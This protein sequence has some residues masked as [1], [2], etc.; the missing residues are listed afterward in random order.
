MNI[1]RGTNFGAVPPSP[2][3]AFITV[4][5]F[6]LFCG[7]MILPAQGNSK[8]APGPLG[9]WKDR[10]LERYVLISKD[11]AGNLEGTYYV[12]A[13]P[14][15]MDFD[16]ISYE[17][18]NLRFG[19]KGNFTF[20][21][22]VTKDGMSIDGQIRLV[23]QKTSGPMILTRDTEAEKIQEDLL[24]PKYTGYTYTPPQETGDGWTCSTMEAEGLKP[25]KI[26]SLIRETREGKYK[27][28]HSILVVKNGKLVLEEYFSGRM[29]RGYPARF[30]RDRKH[31][32]CSITK[33]VT[34]A[35]IGIAIRQNKIKSMHEKISTYFP[36]FRETLRVEGKNQL[37]LEHLMTMTAGFEWDE[38]TYAYVDPRN[39][40]IAAVR[41]GNI[42]K[43]LFER[44]LRANPGE[45]FTYNSALTITQGEILKRAT[46]L[47][48]DRYAEEHLF[49]PLGISDY[50]WNKSAGQVVQTGG[51]LLLRPRDLAKFGQLYLNR[52]KWNGARILSEEWINASTWRHSGIRGVNYAYNWDL[53]QFNLDQLAVEAYYHSG[54]GGQYLFVI[55]RFDMVVVFTSG[56]YD[57]P[58]SSQPEDMLSR[59]ILPAVVLPPKQKKPAV[60][61]VSPHMLDG[62]TGT[63]RHEKNVSGCVKR[64]GNKL[65]LKLR[66]RAYYRAYPA[67]GNRFF[68]RV[69]DNELTFLK[70]QEGKTTH[71]KILVNG[72]EQR[73]EKVSTHFPDAITIDYFKKLPVIGFAFCSLFFLFVQVF[74]VV[75]FILRRFRNGKV[76]GEKAGK[77]RSSLLPGQIMSFISSAAG[78][79]ATL[80]LLPEIKMIEALLNSGYYNTSPGGNV[81]AWALL[82]IT[83]VLTVYLA[84]AWRRQSGPLHFCIL[85]SAVVVVNLLFIYLVWSPGI[86]V[87]FR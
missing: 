67:S 45:S 56:N 51:G 49:K 35:L 1:F 20:E 84:V 16:T 9:Y 34:S 47:P 58:L 23:K 48:V 72:I 85:L 76:A 24:N 75:T 33:S 77:T 46:S 66:S 32:I 78:F 26:F 13:T 62:Y 70:N 14:G 59:C 31:N 44:P 37:T 40:Y 86:I 65:Y 64:V 71:Y 2:L 60:I 63:Y 38:R 41:S 29:F 27:N 87:F 8:N 4:M 79:I 74:W 28:I 21:G 12:C 25:D 57:H 83:V 43:Y 81:T 6:M 3:Y 15:A 10:G 80:E 82:L 68:F 39:S 11:P 42:L 7:S 50:F 30:S 22:T 36:E 5:A 55:P 17:N 61:H 69:N 19:V 18:G 52:G 53:A 73:A 54:R